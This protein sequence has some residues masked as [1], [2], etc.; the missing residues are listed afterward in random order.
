MNFNTNAV[1]RE[2]KNASYK[3]SSKRC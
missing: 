2:M 1:E 3:Q